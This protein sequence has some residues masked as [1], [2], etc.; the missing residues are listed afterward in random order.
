[1]L[2]NNFKYYDK[3]PET[4]FPPIRENKVG[5]YDN[6]YENSDQLC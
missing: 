6:E 4:Y 1:M 2:R 5:F 3:L